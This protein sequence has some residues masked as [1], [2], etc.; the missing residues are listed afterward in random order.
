M[1]NFSAKAQVKA[2]LFEGIVVAGY[3]DNGA[4][5]NCTGP[6]IKY[7]SKPFCV[8][9]GFSPSLKFKEDKVTGSATK[10]SVVTPSLGFGL[11]LAYKHLAF[12][13]PAFYTG[14][15]AASD[16]KWNLGAGL[17]YKF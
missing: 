12:Q 16:G 4:Y 17:G 7:T 6:A 3:V 1:L 14:K 9:L 11:T 2:S 15:T 8:I 10:N 13:L 5:V